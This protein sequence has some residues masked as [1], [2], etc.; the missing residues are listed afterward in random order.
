MS[1]N[2]IT[3][4]DFVTSL[5][6]SGTAATL[7]AVPSALAAPNDAVVVES[8]PV[9]EARPSN[10]P[11]KI[12]CAERL[13]PEEVEKIRS[14]GKNIDLIMLRDRSELKQRAGEAEVILGVVDRET[15]LKASNLK[16]VQNWAAG[17]DTLPRELMQHPCVLT[18]MQRIYAPVIA[19]TAVGFMLSLARGLAQDSIPRFR[20]RKWTRE[21]SVPLVDLYQKTLVLVGLGGIGTETARRAHYGFEMKVLAVDPKPLPKPQFVAE[22]HDPGWLMEMVPQADILMSAAPLTKETRKMFNE[23]I[24]G[25]MKKSAYFINV[26]RG[27]LVDQAALARALKEGWIQGAGLDVTDPEP[28][29][30]EDPLWDCPHLIITP[31]NSGDAPIRQK[32]HVALVAE[33]VRRYSSGLPMLNVV[34]KA[35]GY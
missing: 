17:V 3:R 30:A 11:I 15:V 27:G 24:F 16:W 34:D 29:P 1:K 22:L 12:L 26:T 28:L 5:A 31:H 2:S 33:N 6:V 10:G 23:N 18:N 9:V 8:F 7:S 35:R 21:K 19:E 20:E 4:R 25:K 14:A 13:A 32:R